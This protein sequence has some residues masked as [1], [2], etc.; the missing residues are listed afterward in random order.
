MS[1]STSASTLSQQ[2]SREQEDN[3]T[4]SPDWLKPVVN[5]PSKNFESNIRMIDPSL[6][7]L[8]AVV[9]GSNL[10]ATCF[11]FYESNRLWRTKYHRTDGEHEQKLF[12]FSGSGEF[13]KSPTQL[14][15]QE[16]LMKIQ[17]AARWNEPDAIA[18]GSIH[19]FKALGNL[20][21]R[22][23]SICSL[24]DHENNLVCEDFEQNLLTSLE[25]CRQLNGWNQF[26]RLQVLWKEFHKPSTEIDF[27]GLEKILDRL[28]ARFEK[29]R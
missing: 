27:E 9:I 7:Q 23:T 29:A 21:Q 16:W 1:A 20:F 12:E 25:V 13:P 8:I 15:V 28:E 2:L 6:H 5:M 26:R 11:E 14:T 17:Q 19:D 24:L 22:M 18:V 3:T 4:K 10:R